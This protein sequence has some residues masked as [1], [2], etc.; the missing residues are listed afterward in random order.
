[1]TIIGETP[2]NHTEG[3]PSPQIG[4]G[5]APPGEVSEVPPPRR[6]G[7]RRKNGK[8]IAIGVGIATLCLL[9]Y[10]QVRRLFDG[11][12]PYAPVLFPSMIALGTICFKD[13]SNYR[14]KWIRWV[15]II[16]VLAAAAVGVAYQRAQHLEKAAAAAISQANIDGLKGQ[17]AAAQQAQTDNTRQFLGSLQTL[18]DKVSALQTK[19]ATEELQ[20]QLAAV[21]SELEETRKALDP[22][23]AELLFSF[24]P[25]VPP[26]C[27]ATLL[28]RSET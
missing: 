4:E 28:F 3:A 26:R 16:F 12:L 25:I 27:T 5:P 9:A 24:A 17:V 20:K 6:S 13:W 15:L 8:R 14:P 11:L 23:K 7:N 19:I 1:M 2:Q 18:S 21:K 10:W 22:P